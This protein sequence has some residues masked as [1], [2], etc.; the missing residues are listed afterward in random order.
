MQNGTLL[1]P[2]HFLL[3]THIMIALSTVFNVCWF[4]HMK[5][6]FFHRCQ[7]AHQTLV[8][9]EVCRTV[10][11]SI[12]FQAV[13]RVNWSMFYTLFALFLLHTY[14]W[15]TYFP[16]VSDDTFSAS[17]LNSSA[18]EEH[19]VINAWSE[20]QHKSVSTRQMQLT[21]CKYHSA[22]YYNS[23]PL[24]PLPLFTVPCPGSELATLF[25]SGLM[26]P[27]PNLTGTSWRCQGV[28]QD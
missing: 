9:A 25:I 23:F 3:F 18:I 12:S 11:L 8:C 24:F 27:F 13:C 2:T 28:Q 16:R 10:F 4:A 15:S 14:S 17:A 7:W 19:L 22:F 1:R 5:S 20:R 26:C 21:T 6:I